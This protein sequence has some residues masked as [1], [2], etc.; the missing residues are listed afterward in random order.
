MLEFK[1]LSLRVHQILGRIRVP[2]GSGIIKDMF[3]FLLTYERKVN[4]MIGHMKGAGNEMIG[5]MKIP[6]YRGVCNE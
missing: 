1:H 5:W 2:Q 3:K 6:V 4:E